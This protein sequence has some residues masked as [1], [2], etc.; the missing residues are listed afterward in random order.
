MMKDFPITTVPFT[1]VKEL[2]K[3]NKAHL[4]KVEEALNMSDSLSR[5]ATELETVQ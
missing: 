2:E 5:A 4:K 1:P 3:K